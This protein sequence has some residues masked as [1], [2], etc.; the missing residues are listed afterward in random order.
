LIESI[1]KIGFW[2]MIKADERFKPQEY[3]RSDVTTTSGII[4]E[5]KL[6]ANTDIGLKDIFETP[7]MGAPRYA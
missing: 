4:E 7:S 5:L 1:S 6:K 2:L 3:V